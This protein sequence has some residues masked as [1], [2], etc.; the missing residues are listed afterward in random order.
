MTL[1]A[2][3]WFPD[4]Q[5]AS[6]LRWWDGHAWGAATR[7]LPSTPE[8]VVPIVVA[9]VGPAFSVHTATIRTRAWA[10]G[11]GRD[12]RL[13][14][15]TVLAVLLA[16]TSILINPLGACSALALVCR[17][18]GVV[19]P[20]ATGGWAVAARSASSSAVVVAVATGAVAASAQFHLF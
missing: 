3:G 7:V 19:R 12:R 8:P 14:V 2:A 1:P 5:D 6:R 16:L 18:V 15:F 4:P 17:L 13:C 20:G 9:P 11:G 10:S